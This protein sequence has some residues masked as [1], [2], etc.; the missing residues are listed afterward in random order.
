LLGRGSRG[1]LILAMLVVLVGCART[2]TP[3]APATSV[4]VSAS[5]CPVTIAAASDAVPAPV[6]SFEIGGMI[7]PAGMTPPPLRTFYGNDAIWVDLGTSDGTLVGVPEAAGH[8]G[9]KF[10][11]YRLVDGLL[12]VTVRR[13]D[14]PSGDVWIS[15]PQGYGLSDFQSMGISFPSVGCWSVTETVA[16]RDLDFVVRIVSGQS[17]A[18][19]ASFTVSGAS[20]AFVALV[21]RF[22]DAFNAGDLER[23]AALFADDAN[24]SDC[25]F[26]THTIVE[27]Q[28]RD[29]IR[30]WLAAR[31]A[32]H[33]RL[34]IGSIF[35]HNPDS[36]RAVGV[37]FTKRT[38]DTI[39]RLGAPDGIAPDVDAKVVLD[40]AGARLAA[41]ANGPGG[42]DPGV[43]LREC[44][45]TPASASPGS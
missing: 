12:A 15:V 30:G 10:G 43:V 24:V 32:D 6:A 44:S 21:V 14:G 20:P 42:A 7:L 40:A 29:A 45:V 35:N 17:P 13:L 34:V 39:A 33:D 41:F 28:G 16:S 9:A 5:S 27:G 1:L 19:T 38:S 18:P 23:A 4:T 36:D 2:V 37:E 26:T 11:T 22:V 25:D 8:L 3:T 31:F